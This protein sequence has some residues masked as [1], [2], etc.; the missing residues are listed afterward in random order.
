MLVNCIERIVLLLIVCICFWEPFLPFYCPPSGVNFLQDTIFL[1]QLLLGVTGLSHLRRAEPFLRSPASVLQWE[2]PGLRDMKAAE[3]AVVDAVL[4]RK[5]TFTQKRVTVVT[6]TVSLRC[7][8]LY[9]DITMPTTKSHCVCTLL[10]FV[11]E[12]VCQLRHSC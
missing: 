12:V 3:S 9:N 6:C 5:F 8:T 11:H 1:S 10:C 2:P 4:G 7:R